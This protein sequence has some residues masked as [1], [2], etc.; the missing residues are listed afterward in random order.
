MLRLAPQRRQQILH[1]LD[2]RLDPAARRESNPTQT[3]DSVMTGVGQRLWDSNCV[4]G[5]IAVATRSSDGTYRIGE[6]I[7][8]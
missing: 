7:V 3:S 8:R 6:G 2:L 5:V 4:L 1:H